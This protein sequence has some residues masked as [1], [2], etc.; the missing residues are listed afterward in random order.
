MA[1]PGSGVGA[2]R[3]KIEKVG[4]RIYLRSPWEPG[5]P[6]RCKSISG[7]RWSPKSKAWTYA[8]DLEVCRMLREEFGDELQIGSELWDW[9]SRERARERALSDML[10]TLKEN[11]MDHLEIPT[12]VGETSEI[13]S[14]ALRSRPYQ[15]PGARYLARARTA[16]LADQPGLGKTIQTLAG[17]VEGL[18]EGGRVLV[19]APKTAVNTTWAEEIKKWMADYEPGYTVTSLASLTPAKVQSALVEYMQ[20]DSIF[21]KGEFHF[22]LAN[23]EMVRIVS[24]KK[25]PKKVEPCN[26][27]NEFCDAADKHKGSLVPRLPQL[28]QTEWDAIVADETHKWLINSIA[29]AKGVSQVGLGFAKLPLKDGGMKV[30]L[31]GTPLKGK[32]Y[33]L[34]GTIHWLRPQVYTAKW[35]WIE[36][37]FVVDEDGYG[38]TIGDLRPERKEAFYRALNTMMLRR[39]KKEIRDL[40]PDWMP[41]EKIYHDVWVDMDPKQAKAYKAIELSGEAEIKGGLLDTKGILSEFTRMK[42]FA[43]C[44]GKMESGKFVPDLPSAKFDWLM[45]FLEARGIESGGDLSDDVRKVVIASQFTSM[46]N[47][48]A[49]ELKSKRIAC[50]TLTGATKD[51]DR[52]AQVKAFQDVDHVRVFLINT[53]AGGASITLDAA[54][55]IVLMDETWVPDEQEQ[56]EDRVHRASNVKHQV[57]VWYVRARGT[58][59]EAI[60]NT[61]VDKAEGNHVVLDAQRGLAFARQYINQKR[62]GK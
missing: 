34:F 9:A 17:L 8:L 22:L 24:E 5:M 58:V 7:A 20:E 41:P 30:A 25:C 28:F 26:G 32:K 54:D 18:P 36:R 62:S 15:I 31:S 40:N 14:E 48:W 21:G 12:R 39:T 1:A 38:R 47:L 44:Y 16:L 37:Y 6:D 27:M 56:V 29:R 51:R 19:L 3:V 33:N 43:S 57:D 50:Y 55:D 35:A 42:Q 23:A 4:K 53:N 60:A 59:E 11:P 49:K 52:S 61:N 10:R 13:L 2:G 46:I 45:E